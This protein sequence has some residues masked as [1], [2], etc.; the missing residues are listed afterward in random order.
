MTSSKKNTIQSTTPPLQAVEDQDM[1]VRKGENMLPNPVGSTS[2]SKNISLTDF[3][4]R[5]YPNSFYRRRPLPDFK[6]VFI[7]GFDGF[8]YGMRTAMLNDTVRVSLNHPIQRTPVSYPE[9]GVQN[10][11][12]SLSIAEDSIFASRE[13]GITDA[14]S[15][16]RDL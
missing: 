3:L 5:K 8:S 11:S 15:D 2:T 9:K 4:A 7:P 6:G 1:Q 16:A 13:S 10:G 14:C 12:P